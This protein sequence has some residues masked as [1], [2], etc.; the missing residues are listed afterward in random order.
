MV[1][2]VAVLA[3]SCTDKQVQLAAT[4]DAFVT[5]S[6]PQTVYDGKSEP[7][8]GYGYGTRKRLYEGSVT[9]PALY[10]GVG[11]SDTVKDA[12]FLGGFDISGIEGKIEHATLVFFIN[13]MSSTR[14]RICLFVRPVN[15]KWSESDL[16][17]NDVF[18]DTL[19]GADLTDLVNPD[20]KRA[21]LVVFDSNVTRN[22][23]EPVIPNRG[24]YRYVKIDVTDIVTGWQN[25]PD[26]NNGLM[27]DPMWMSDY[28]Y[29]TTND[30]DELTDFGI[31]EIVPSEWFDWDGT[32]PES[33]SG[34]WLPV[35]NRA[36]RKT[37]MVP[38]LELT[39]AD[40]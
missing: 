28:R 25:S 37:R 6:R 35:T 10:L 14:K 8:P 24:A 16:S 40:E 27:L 22:L 13:Y 32:V 39:I 26:T 38:H 15:K 12:V 29:I 1:L 7:V 19:P 21:K 34:E 18:V 31:I 4:Q 33:F 5:G 20:E 11:G 3:V 23:D 36:F 9:Y 30:S 2:L 17:Y